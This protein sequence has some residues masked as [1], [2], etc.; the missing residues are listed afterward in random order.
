M[1]SDL[2][3]FMLTLILVSSSTTLETGKTL[4]WKV[5]RIL[6]CGFLYYASLSRD[7]FG[8]DLVYGENMANVFYKLTMVHGLMYICTSQ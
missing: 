1:E 3:F 6:I 2:H 4:A 8:P 5:L 7:L